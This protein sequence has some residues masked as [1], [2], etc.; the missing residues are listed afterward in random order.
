MSL[1]SIQEALAAVIRVSTHFNEANCTVD[2]PTPLGAG[3][4]AV[5]IIRYAGDRVELAGDN[6]EWGFTWTLMV[7]LW[8]RQNGLLS[9]YNTLVSTLIQE[10]YTTVLARPTLYT[11]EATGIWQVRPAGSGD[12][13]RYT[14]ELQNWWTV[15]LPFEV[16]ERQ[17]ITLGE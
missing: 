14:G 12:P 15:S 6:N 7:D 3:H 2:D 17:V 5:A 16:S 13:D 4:D 11:D 8:F 1:S 10:I 9:R